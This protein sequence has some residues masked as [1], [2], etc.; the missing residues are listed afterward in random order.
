MFTVEEKD[1]MRISKIYDSL[2]LDSKIS[3]SMFVLDVFNQ[4]LEILKKE[5]YDITKETCRC[6]GKT[7][8]T[9]LETFVNGNDEEMDCYSCNNCGAK[10][11]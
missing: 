5:K 3:F 4:E 6:C 7:G 11:C 10:I 2:T 1:V 9:F 8:F